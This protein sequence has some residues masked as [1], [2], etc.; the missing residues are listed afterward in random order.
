MFVT[1]NERAHEENFLH[2]SSL[3][4][5][6]A[7]LIAAAGDAAGGGDGDAAGVTK[8]AAS[9]HARSPDGVSGSS[10]ESGSEVSPLHLDQEKTKAGT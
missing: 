1:Q 5:D 4:G 9:A 10:V 7:G 8:P 2:A 6:K 3:A